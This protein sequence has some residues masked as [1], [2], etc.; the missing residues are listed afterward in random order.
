MVEYFMKNM[1]DL[2]WMLYH[3]ILGFKQNILQDVVVERKNTV[4]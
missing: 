2:K 4:S 1:K 3:Q